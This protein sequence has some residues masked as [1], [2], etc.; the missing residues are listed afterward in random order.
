MTS[1]KKC[2]AEIEWVTINNKHVPVEQEYVNVH[3]QQFGNMAI[4][5]DDNEYVCGIQV[6]DAFESEDGY[7]IGR[8]VH[9][10]RCHEGR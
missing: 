3:R 7:K 9:W 1:C 8:V 2:S 10:A 4:I 6:G 5:T